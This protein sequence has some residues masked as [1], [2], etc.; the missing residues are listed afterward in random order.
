MMLKKRTFTIALCGI[1]SAVETVILLLTT[2]IPVASYALSAFAGMVSAVI[3]IEC[4]KKRALAVYFVVSV[5]SVLLVA[6]KEAVAL[7]ILLF[8]HYPVIKQCIEQHIVSFRKRMILKIMIFSVTV[9]AFYFLC[10]YLL[11]IPNEQFTMFGIN[12]PVLFLVGSVVIF[13]MFDKAFTNIISIYFQKYR[14]RLL[15]YRQ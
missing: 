5:L 1:V 9:T 11:G 7:Y 12:I 3:V 13:V 6:D 4:G 2:L 10:I 8:G 15:R 14:S